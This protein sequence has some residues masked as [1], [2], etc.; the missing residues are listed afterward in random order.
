MIHSLLLSESVMSICHN[1]LAIAFT[2]FAK[3]CVYFISTLIRD[4]W[5]KDLL[6]RYLLSR[7]KQ[8]YIYNITNHTHI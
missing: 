3:T 2:C 8:S 6:L 5:H 7:T 1:Y 4:E